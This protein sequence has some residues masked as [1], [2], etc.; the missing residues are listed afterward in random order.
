MDDLYLDGEFSFFGTAR[1]LPI[2]LAALGITDE[3]ELMELKGTKKRR[4]KKIDDPDFMVCRGIASQNAPELSMVL[5]PTMKP[6]IEKDIPKV[7]QAIRQTTSRKMLYK[8]LTRIK[9]SYILEYGLGLSLTRFA[10]HGRPSCFETAYA[11]TRVFSHD[12]R[13]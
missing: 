1:M 4:G 11:V 6:V 10:D 9:A 8:I 13:A 2:V 3:N 5:Q 12:E 7:V